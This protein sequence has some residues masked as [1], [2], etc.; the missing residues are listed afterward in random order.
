MPEMNFE[1]M[2]DIVDQLPQFWLFAKSSLKMIE[3]Q[4]SLNLDLNQSRKLKE[5]RKLLDNDLDIEYNSDTDKQIFLETILLAVE[6]NA[7]PQLLSD[8][9]RQFVAQ[10]R[11]GH[12][13]S[14]RNVV[15]AALSFVGGRLS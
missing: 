8:S 9:D 6:P 4:E 10:M 5:I 2:M 15:I 7:E 1:L 12:T 11:N 3:Q 13:H 14:T